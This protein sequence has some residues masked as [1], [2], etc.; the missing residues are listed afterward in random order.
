MVY[1]YLYIFID[2]RATEMVG[3]MCTIGR[4]V[5]MVMINETQNYS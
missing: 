1:P 2:K 3:F 5:R 4:Q